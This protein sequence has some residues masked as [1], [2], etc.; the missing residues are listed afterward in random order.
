M[1]IPLCAAAALMLLAAPAW[2]DENKPKP[3]E[4]T[5]YHIPYKLTTTNH[6]MVRV[7]LNGKGPFNFIVDTGAPALFVATKVA[8]KAGAE[9]EKDSMGVFDTL[10]LEGGLKMEK[11][12]GMIADPFQLEGMN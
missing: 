8:K 3:K 9:A 12:E 4:P 5:T 10:E 11:I 6:V 2:A 1:R 7:K